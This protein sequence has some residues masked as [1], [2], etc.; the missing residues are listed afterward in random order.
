MDHLLSERHAEPAAM[1][2]QTVRAGRALGRWAATLRAAA[3]Y[4]LLMA[5]A[6]IIVAPLWWVVASSFTTPETVWSNVLPFTWRAFWPQTLSLDAY[7]AIFA[8]GMG[9]AVW[10]TLLISFATVALTLVASAMAGF[11]FA[12]FAFPGKQAL[13]WLVL[14]SFIVP[15]DIT[16]I[17]SYILVNNLGWLNSWQGLII[18][19]VANSVVIF[20]FQQFFA[21]IP[22]ALVDAARVDGASWPRILLQ[23][24]LPL[25]RPVLVTA[26]ILIFLG[27]WNNYFW[28]TL[29]A[30]DP[31]FRV[32]QVA[33]AQ[34][35]H[36]QQLTLWDRIFAGSTIAAL[37]PILL[38]VPL[39][40]Y[41]V[42]SVMSAGIQG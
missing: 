35:G 38:T 14:L 18:P 2:P 9:R 17:P 33:I 30:P 32:I 7:R 20:L 15:G 5:V 23:I 40:R 8:E 28:P 4:G 41:Y 13:F 31:E 10:N 19:A 29:V 1:S 6:V 37:I 36:S 16:I 21:E 11:A 12:R 27:Q 42:R 3:L 25:S 24:I 22:E 26:A 34:I 39:Q